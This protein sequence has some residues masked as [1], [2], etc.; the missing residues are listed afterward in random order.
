MSFSSS[1]VSIGQSISRPSSIVVKPTP[2][3]LGFDDGSYS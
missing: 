3:A 2:A 1:T